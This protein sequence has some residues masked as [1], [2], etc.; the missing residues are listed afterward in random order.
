MNDI[1]NVGDAILPSIL[2]MLVVFSALVFLIAI[3][4]AISWFMK[5]S[6]EAQPATAP[7]APKEPPVNKVPAKGSLGSLKLY[8]TPDREAAQIMA[9]VANECGKPL[10]ELR[11]MSI[12]RVDRMDR[13]DKIDRINDNGKD[14]DA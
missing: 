9:I 1:K 2:G 11:F 3:I 14:G 4:Y 12:K 13:I 7:V 5:N 8:D 10:N 6:P